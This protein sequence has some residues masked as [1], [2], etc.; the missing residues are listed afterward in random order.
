MKF[1]VLFFILLLAC[2]YPSLAQGSY[3]NCCLRYVQ[4]IKR[5]MRRKITHYRI[6]ETDGGCNIRAVVFAAKKHL[7]ADPGQDWVQ[8]LMV[9]VDK[10]RYKS[11]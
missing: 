6:Q 7:C 10:K 4:S 1:C 8:K 2:M 11:P 5:G 3:E 9:E